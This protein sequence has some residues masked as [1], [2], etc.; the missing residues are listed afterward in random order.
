MGRARPTSGVDQVITHTRLRVRMSK[1]VTEWRD[2]RPEHSGQIT[3][4]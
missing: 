2:Q 3:L 1:F 4:C